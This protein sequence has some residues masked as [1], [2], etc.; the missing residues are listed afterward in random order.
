MG[1]TV[2]ARNAW[3]LILGPLLAVGLATSSAGSSAAPATGSLVPSGHSSSA[4]DNQDAVYA[5]THGVSASVAKQRRLESESFGQLV[6]AAHRVHGERNVDAWVETVADGQIFH[7][8]STS[9]EA[10]TFLEASVAASRLSADIALQST[11]LADKTA[12]LAA[13]VGTT[14]GID[15]YYVDVT[16]GQPVISAPAADLAAVTRA[17]TERVPNARIESSGD[18]ARDENRGGLNLSSCT[19]G[20]SATWNGYQGFFTAAHCTGTQSWQAP[21]STTWNW[22][23]S[24]LTQVF[25]GT[26]DI[27]FRR[28]ATS[29][30]NNMWTGS[31]YATINNGSGLAV[32]GTTYCG[33]GSRSGYRCA[34][35]TSTTYTP[36]YSGACPGGC[37]PNFVYANLTSGG[38][39]GGDSGGPWANGNTAVGIHKGSNGVQVHW[40]KIGYRPASSN[41][42]TG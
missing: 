28:V 32:V 4:F 6:A 25:N 10:V 34:Q 1:A 15:G 16:T 20:F 8:R 2:S 42:Y 31:G 7:L 11:S 22:S 17:I 13:K 18:G 36:T 24:S 40:S 3:I 35:V 41:V 37:G 9:P 29:V 21:G 27:A 26:A 19:S 38:S 33:R 12:D 14:P 39:Q 5:A 30:Y 23:S